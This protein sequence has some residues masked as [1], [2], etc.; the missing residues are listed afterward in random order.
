MALTQNLPTML[1]MFLIASASGIVLF[2]KEFQKS[3]VQPRIVGALL[4]T[5]VNVS[6][7]SVGWPLSYIAFEK[8]EKNQ[9]P[10]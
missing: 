3:R 8:S 7:Q 2:S 1:H 5:L 9:T 6:E 4:A 10:C